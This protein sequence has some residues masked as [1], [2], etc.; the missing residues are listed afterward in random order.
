[1]PARFQLLS[2]ILPALLAAT[3]VAS[4][5]DTVASQSL[6][7]TPSQAL[8]TLTVQRNQ[9][10]GRYVADGVVEA[11]RQSVISAQT[12][13]RVVERPVEAGASVKRGSLLLR[14]D[15]REA[16]Q[17][18][19]ARRAELAAAEAQLANAQSELERTRQL[20]QK[21]LVGQAALDRAETS[22]RAAL[23]QVR[24]LSASSEV[25]T[26]QRSF[27]RLLAPYDGLI[28]AVQ[29][30]VGDMAVPGKPL[31]TVYDPTAMRVIASLPVAQL[32]QWQ[33]EQ[34]LTI[35][36]PDN[37]L[38][39]AASAVTVLPVTDPNAQQ[40]QI[41][42]ELPV[43]PA[44]LLPGM[45]AKVAFPVGSRPRLLVPASA[46]V[47]RGELTAVYVLNRQNGFSLRQIRL[48]GT[49]GDH[50]E[51]VAG[52]SDGETIAL[53]PFAAARQRGTP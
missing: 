42:L 7:Q 29:V 11:V 18:E 34:P 41:R 45:L 5:A 37:A 19:S 35:S 46:V 24:A 30:Q 51:V 10:G 23:A 22:Q 53:D 6:G 2:L 13:G 12:S 1:M 40:V 20:F 44:G 32:G 26:T 33:R 49:D 28:A 48:A 8:P 39:L 31:L 9:S 38:T 17:A 15:D 16:A 21:A 47:Q 25:S 14:I 36:L 27:T 4:A 43:A 52:L 50:V 3:P